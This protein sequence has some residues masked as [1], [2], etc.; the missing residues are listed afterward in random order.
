VC[1][2]SENIKPVHIIYSFHNNNKNPILKSDFLA[3]RKA[4]SITRKIAEAAVE[5]KKKSV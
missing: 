1:H 2:D 5:R 4:R 3:H